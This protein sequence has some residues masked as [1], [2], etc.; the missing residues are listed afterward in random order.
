MEE[1]HFVQAKREFMRG[2]ENNVKSFF[3]N[4]SLFVLIFLTE[5]IASKLYVAAL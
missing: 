3:K 5:K 2:N 4:K 1:F